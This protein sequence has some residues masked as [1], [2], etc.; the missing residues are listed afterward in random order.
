MRV[1]SAKVHES[2]WTIL[3]RIDLE[4]LP[5]AVARARRMQL[6]LRRLDAPPATSS[7]GVVM[8]R[9]LALPAGLATAL[10]RFVRLAKGGVAPL[11][12]RA[13]SSGVAT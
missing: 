8:A 5:E 11:K 1:F 10:I 9:A 2:F 12:S 6:E 7:R 3:T 13:A 4:L